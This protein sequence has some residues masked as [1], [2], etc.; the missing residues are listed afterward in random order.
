M[1]SPPPRWGNMELYTSLNVV[2]AYTRGRP[3]NLPIG[4]VCLPDAVVEGGVV[5]GYQ[6]ADLRFAH[7]L[8]HE[9]TLL[10]STTLK[11]THMIAILL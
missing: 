8:Q 4:G 6:G 10:L 1:V 2:A 7:G 9:H 3:T 11:D 5:A